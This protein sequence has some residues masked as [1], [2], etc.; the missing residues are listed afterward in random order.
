[1]SGFID[2]VLETNAGWLV[3]DHKSFPGGKDDVEAKA[4]TYSGQLACYGRALEAAEH[5]V[6]SLWIH[7]PVSGLLVEVLVPVASSATGSH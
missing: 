5:R 1:M 6:R 4:L 7:F 2:L 3:I